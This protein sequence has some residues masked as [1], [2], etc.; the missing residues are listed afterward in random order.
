MFLLHKVEF[1]TKNI[2][3]P[4]LSLPSRELTSGGSDYSLPQLL[5]GFIRVLHYDIMSNA[6]LLQFKK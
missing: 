3:N 6:L 4:F 5:V 1:A 2:F